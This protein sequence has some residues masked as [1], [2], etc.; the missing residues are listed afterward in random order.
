MSSP[1]D[2]SAAPKLV[3]IRGQ[4]PGIDFVIKP[5]QTVL[6]RTAAGDLHVDVDL[7]SQERPGL[8]FAANHHA[9]I[10]WENG[11]L[12]VEDTGTTH[13]ISSTGHVSCRTPSI[14]CNPMTRSRSAPFNCR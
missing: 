3:V 2:P 14:P 11:S 8:A 1:F 12:A 9:I 10:T 7:D 4:Q 6:G 13:G 5:G